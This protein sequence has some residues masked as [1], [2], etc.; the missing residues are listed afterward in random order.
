MVLAASSECNGAAGPGATRVRGFGEVIRNDESGAAG[1]GATRVRG[2]GEVIRDD[3]LSA[4]GPGAVRVRS[5]GEVIRNDESGATGPRGDP[6][7]QPGTG[8]RRGSG[9]RT[10]PRF[11]QYFRVMTATADES[12]TFTAAA[13]NFGGPK[14]VLGSL[15]KP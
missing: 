4:A 13:S 8:G 5:F 3:E 14:V 6:R 10:S 15:A 7:P 9:C 11:R 12:P 1:P 2:F